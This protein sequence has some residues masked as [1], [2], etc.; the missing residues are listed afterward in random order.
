MDQGDL[1][2]EALSPSPRRGFGNG[3]SSLLLDDIIKM[4]EV[5]AARL[6]TSL[7]EKSVQDE[8]RT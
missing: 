5:E 1:E 4:F 2:S 7:K 6:I 3:A 8:G